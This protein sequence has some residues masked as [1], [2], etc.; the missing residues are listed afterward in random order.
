MEKELQGCKKECVDSSR[1]SP[2]GVHGV[3]G[4]DSH[5]KPR[6]PVDG[7]QQAVDPAIDGASTLTGHPINC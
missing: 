5:S 2:G 6:Q 3:A 1:H 7:V 4:E